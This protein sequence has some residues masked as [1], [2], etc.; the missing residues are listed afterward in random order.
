MLQSIVGLAPLLLELCDMLTMAPLCLL[1]LC[2]MLTMLTQAV[3][4]V[5][6]VPRLHAHSHPGGSIVLGSIRG[7]SSRVTSVSL[8]EHNYNKSSGFG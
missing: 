2:D 6:P 7:R 8:E 3:G 1:E 4:L 5:S